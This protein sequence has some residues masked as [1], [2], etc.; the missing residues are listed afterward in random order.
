MVNAWLRAKTAA[1]D[2]TAAK[3]NK[4]PVDDKIGKTSTDNKIGKASADNKPPLPKGRNN[5]TRGKPKQ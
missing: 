4:A 1:W 5:G 2:S 3:V